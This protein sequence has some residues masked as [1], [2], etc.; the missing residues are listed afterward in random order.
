[1]KRPKEQKPAP[2][3][4]A[5]VTATGMKIARLLVGKPPQTIG[6]L[7]R[8][9]GVT[10]TAINEQ[11]NELMAAGF[12]ERTTE[13]LS[14]RGRPHYLFRATDAAL[15][16]LFAGNQRLVIPAI[17]KAVEKAGGKALVAEVLQQV[18]HDLA[19]HYKARVTGRTPRQRL[20]QLCQLLER[21]GS[22]IEVDEDDA[23]QLCVVKRSCP[24]ISMFEPGRAVCTIDQDMMS[25]VVGAPVR[26]TACRHD[27]A[28]CCTFELEPGRSKTG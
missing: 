24:F 14:G 13:R 6:Q 27:G 8:Q 1:M 17:W 28:P 19:Q 5:T 20:R 25:E 12:V 21:E 15:L 9:M 11:L 3:P 2:L 7:I 16:L 4:D 10:R 18:S 23:G 22:L 26:R